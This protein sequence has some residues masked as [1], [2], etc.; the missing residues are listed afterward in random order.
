MTISFYKLH[1][2]G[3]DFLLLD[4]RGVGQER[5]AEDPSLLPAL[6]RAMLDRRR[7][8]GGR[9]LLAIGG[10]GREKA[11]GAESAGMIGAAGDGALTLRVFAADGKE[12]FADNDARLC[13]ARWAFDTGHGRGNTVILSETDQ[14]TVLT[15][16]DSR[17]FSF[18]LALPLSSVTGGALSAEDGLSARSDIRV[19]AVNVAVYRIRLGSNYAVV[20]SNDAGVRIRALRETL[21]QAF[22]EDRFL[23]VSLGGRDLVRFVS[24]EPADRLSAAATAFVAAS[25]AKRADTAVVAEWRGR[26]AAVAYAFFNNHNRAAAAPLVDRAR[27]WLEWRPEGRLQAAGIAEYVFEGKFDFLEL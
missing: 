22:P 9:A 24:A 15:A 5:L 16:L 14:K 20:F 27:F 3:D 12:L 25:L 4:R 2:A 18:E 1:V 17:S 26:G 21:K 13:A 10:R 7:G 19:G 11:I 8:V 6:A 23:A